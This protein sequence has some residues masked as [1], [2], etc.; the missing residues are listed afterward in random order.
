MSGAATANGG[1]APS[2][3]WYLLALAIGLAGFAGMAAFMLP[4]LLGMADEFIH[5]V[6]PGE[7]ELTLEAP[8]TYTIF[9]EQRSVVGDRLYVS[10]N[11]SGLRIVVKSATTGN[12]IPI[13]PAA[14]SQTYTFGSRSGTSA[15]AFN[16]AEPGRFRLVAA[17]EDGRT[18]PQ[19]VLAIGHDFLA[20]L[21]ITI[22][23]SLAIVFAFMAAAVVLVVGVWRRRKAARPEPT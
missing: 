5:V 17:Y 14:V 21:M 13:V 20:G 8:G 19:A 18:E 10:D 11:I 12:E 7:A 3:W 2:R 1:H 9:H 23:G 4:R 6:V 15:F 16:I 22:L